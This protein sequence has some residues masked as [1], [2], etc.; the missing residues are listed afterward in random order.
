M[1]VDKPGGADSVVFLHGSADSRPAESRDTAW[2][3][4]GPKAL[5]LVIDDEP[6]MR[7]VTARFLEVLEYR[8]EKAPNAYVGSALFGLHRDDFAAV[9][10]DLKMPGMDGWQCLA[11]IRAIRP[12]IPVVICSGYEPDVDQ[13]RMSRRHV[14]FL[15]KP[16]GVDD[17]GAVLRN[18]LNESTHRRR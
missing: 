3:I 12:D 14:A 16:F 17:M 8:V 10:L 15:K 2:P 5:V 13:L 18:L 7:H 4:R 11:E 6:Q 9:I 1:S